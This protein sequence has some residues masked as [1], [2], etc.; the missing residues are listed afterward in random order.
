MAVGS[1]I[2]YHV[3]PRFC[4]SGFVG[5]DIFFVISGFVVARSVSKETYGAFSSFILDFY[6]RRFF[7]I[8]PALAFVVSSTAFFAAILLPS[9]PD[10]NYVLPTG[11]AALLGISNVL[12]YSISG[13]YFSDIAQFNVFT[14]TWSLGVEEQF[15]LIFPSIAALI[16]SHRLSRSRTGIVILAAGTISSFVALGFVGNGAAGFYL[17]V[18]RFWEFGLGVLL[19]LSYVPA[20]RILLHHRH[21]SAVVTGAALGLLGYSLLGLDEA[22]FPFPSALAPALAAVILIGLIAT[23]NGGVAGRFLSWYPVVWVGQISYPLYLWH[24]VVVVAIRWFGPADPFLGIMLTFVVTFA[25]AATTHYLVERPI[26]SWARQRSF[27][28][29]SL[30]AGAAL[31]LGGS[32][33]IVGTL[34]LLAPRLALSITAD[35]TVWRTTAIPSA[36]SGDC[37]TASSAVWTHG[38]RFITITP[39]GCIEKGDRPR[40]F[41]A[42]DSHAGAYFRLGQRLAARYGVSVVVM[43]KA[44]CRT[45][46]NVEDNADPACRNFRSAV[47]ARLQKEAR[48]QDR[49]FI[50]ALYLPRYRTTFRNAPDAVRNVA[51]DEGMPSLWSPVLSQL[52]QTGA[53]IVFEAPKPLLKTAPFRCSDP[54]T[55]TSAYCSLAPPA[56]GKSELLSMRE[57]LLRKLRS[58]VAEQPRT[59]IWDPFPLL[60]RSDTCSGIEGGQPLFYDTD[61]LS[62][63]GNDIL[64]ESFARDVLDIFPLTKTPEVSVR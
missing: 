41:I 36:A 21:L 51:S 25:L 11:V 56:F 29:A 62:G 9:V 23:G 17:V 6:K 22:L 40:L 2:L 15:Y 60:C 4:P 53:H 18:T 24:W 61:H 63:Y 1:V 34:I 14:H 45:L 50:T 35:R 13:D 55:T 58:L 16:F 7:R 49:I 12:L 19:F 33:A 59:A 39:S 27:R 3:N 44:G 8:Y 57:P 32:V 42:G 48:P 52:L 5:V 54:W 30:L 20:F 43:T 31:M 47:L 26:R 37:D 10:T 28:A 46:P 38:G 64:V